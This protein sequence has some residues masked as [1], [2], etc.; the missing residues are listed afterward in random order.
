MD[1]E[2]KSRNGNG[3]G[4]FRKTSKDGEPEKW[5]G[6]KQFGTKPNGKPN[7]KAVYG[8][9]EKECRKKMAKYEK[10]FKPSDND[11]SKQIFGDYLVNWFNLFKKPKLKQRTFDTM[12]NTIKTRF[13]NYPISKFQLSQITNEKLQHYINQLA[14]EERVDNNGNILQPYSKESIKKIYNLIN[15]CLSYAVDK[16]HIGKN[17]IN[18]TSL[19]K[20]E[21]MIT[22]TKEIEFFDKED[23]KKIYNECIRKFNNGKY[24]YSNNG[25]TLA[26]LMWT[27]LRVGEALAVRY[28]DFDTTNRVLK[29]NKALTRILTRNNNSNNKY[30]YIVSTPKSK[31]SI[32][33]VQLSK[34]AIFIFD[35]MKRVNNPNSDN[36]FVFVT[37]NGEHIIDRNL[38]RTLNSIQETVETKIQNSGLHVLRHSYASYLLYNNIDV[39]VVSKLLGHAKV[40]TTYNIYVH[41]I[42]EQKISAM[43]VFD[44]FDEEF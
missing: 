12:E 8:N 5:T 24:V 4:S 17:P 26:F 29:I 16:E 28:E 31:T 22:K 23:M 30:E 41:I 15:N 42:D 3:E 34:Q 35:E 11:A 9:S 39:A 44:K 1:D 18:G 21:S 38:R 2:R 40:S 33:T 25:L 19:P 10:E 7:I 36:E 6:R 32:R 37:K 14:T 13:L 27:G 43:N 20:E